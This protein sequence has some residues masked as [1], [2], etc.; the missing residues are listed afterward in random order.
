VARKRFGLHSLALAELDR[1]RRYYQ[2][3]AVK[4]RAFVDAVEEALSRMAEQP[5]RYAPEKTV[6][7]I[8][9]RSVRL[10]RFPFRVHFGD[11]GDSLRVYAIGHVKRRPDYWSRR[12]GH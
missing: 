9:I 8:T 4:G 5:E 12:V 7:G 10:K 3:R 1:E 2:R 6:R 11:L